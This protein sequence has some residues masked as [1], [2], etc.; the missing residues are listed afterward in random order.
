MAK[1]PTKRRTAK[2]AKP[3]R[4]P[5]DPVTGQQSL[6][7]PQT[8]HATFSGGRGR[9]MTAGERMAEKARM[10]AIKKRYAAHRE[11]HLKRLARRPVDMQR[12]GYE[13]PNDVAAF[14]QRLHRDPWFHPDVQHVSIAEAEERI[15]AAYMDGCRQGFIEGFLYGEDKARPGALKNRERLRELNFKKL[16]RLQLADRN[17]KIVAAFHRLE[18]ELPVKDDRYQRLADEAK[19]GNRGRENWPTSGRQIGNIVR[20]AINRRR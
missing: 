20:A 3:K 17:A 19:A 15:E 13:L 8:G 10:L 18:S 9:P 11:L 1:R 4:I 16:E 7:D 12:D 5:R 2:R 6:F 14:L